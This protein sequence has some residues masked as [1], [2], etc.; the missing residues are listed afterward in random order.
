[1][2]ETI[3]VDRLVRIGLTRYEARVYVALIRRDGSTA[4]DMARLTG[5]PRPR[6]YDVLASLVAKGIAAERPGL[7]A[8]Y[9]AIDPRQAMTRLV[10]AHEQELDLLRGDAR[11]VADE[12]APAF[13]EG[14]RHHDPLDYVEVIRDRDTVARRFDE[15][16][17]NVADEL[18][19]FSKEP[20]VVPVDQNVVGMKAAAEHLVRS[21]YEFPLLRDAVR[22]A[23]VRR[24]VEIGEQAR[25]VPELPMKLA[26]IDER[27]VMFALPDPIAGRDD[28][29]SVIIEHAALAR[30]LKVAFEAVWQTA[31]TVDEACAE[32]GIA[33]DA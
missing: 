27:I 19:A 8:K 2:S 12:L 16:Q 18:L 21:I 22:R 11:T 5:V 31:L 10:E 6:V 13:A 23:G 3:A 9:V 4:A 17:A 32:L 14:N 33:A 15:L 1:V 20:A 24:F 29:T 25:F 30:S 26:I 7:A 28:L